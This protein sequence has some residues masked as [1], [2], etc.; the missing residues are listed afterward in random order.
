M[1]QQAG[2]GNR[3][4]LEEIGERIDPPAGK[5]LKKG[6]KRPAGGSGPRPFKN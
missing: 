5:G 3:V 6:Q 1:T 2:T 4:W